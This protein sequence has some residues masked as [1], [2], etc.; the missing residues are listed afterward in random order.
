MILQPSVFIDMQ[1]TKLSTGYYKPIMVTALNCCLPHL[2][3][4]LL[5]TF[6]I[7]KKVIENIHS[8]VTG[9]RDPSTFCSLGQY[10]FERSNDVS[11]SDYYLVLHQSPSSSG[12]LPGAG[13]Q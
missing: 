12:C 8:H 3:S 5:K 7:L 9:E 13:S 11:F 2:V 10:D 4:V 1:M 6:H